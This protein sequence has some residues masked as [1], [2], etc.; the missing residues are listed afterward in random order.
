[1]ELLPLVRRCEIKHKEKNKKVGLLAILAALWLLFR[2]KP[3]GAE[4][5]SKMQVVSLNWS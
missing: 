5:E 3:S 4:P 1:L 2:A